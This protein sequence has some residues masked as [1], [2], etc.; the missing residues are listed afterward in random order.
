MSKEVISFYSTSERCTACLFQHV[1]HVDDGEK[2]LKNY[3]GSLGNVS[4]N[5]K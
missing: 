2:Y 3:R 1:S 4:K 5:E